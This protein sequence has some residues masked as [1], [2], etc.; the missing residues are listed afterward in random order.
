VYHAN[1][2]HFLQSFHIC[3]CSD[4]VKPVEGVSVYDGMKGIIITATRT[5]EME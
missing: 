5:F 2:I 3:F 1:K 4:Q